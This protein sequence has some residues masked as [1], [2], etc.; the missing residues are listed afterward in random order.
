MKRALLFLLSLLAM[1]NIC[2]AQENIEDFVDVSNFNNYMDWHYAEFDMPWP[3]EPEEYATMKIPD[4]ALYAAANTAIPP[5]DILSILCAKWNERY[6]FF[7]MNCLGETHIFY[8]EDGNWLGINPPGFGSLEYHHLGDYET[9]AEPFDPTSMFGQRINNRLVGTWKCEVAGTLD[10]PDHTAYVEFRSNG[11]GHTWWEEDGVKTRESRFL[12]TIEK[13]PT[14]LKSKDW[15]VVK[16]AYEGKK[17]TKYV[18]YVVEGDSMYNVG[19][20]DL[21]HDDKPSYYHRVIQDE[22]SANDVNIEPGKTA[23]L[24]IGLKNANEYVLALFDLILPEGIT[25]ANDDEGKY[26]VE[27]SR[28]HKKNFAD[29]VP[30][31]G[32]YRI[33]IMDAS[34]NKTIAPG[35]GTMATI[36]LQASADAKSGTGKIIADGEADGSKTQGFFTDN[37]EAHYLKDVEFKINVNG[38]AKS[39]KAAADVNGDGVVNAADIVEIINIIMTAE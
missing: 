30:I 10:N 18:N 24:E 12:Y 5:H 22:L 7:F 28:W 32:G 31:D 11:S 14:D 17:M 33:L 39:K 8:D 13:E 23:K 6:I 16:R 9:K 34:G 21:L 36:T 1:S 25:I 15:V 35:E 20:Y 38:G 29:V 26:A 27:L 37:G 3:E 4:W 19:D 2:F